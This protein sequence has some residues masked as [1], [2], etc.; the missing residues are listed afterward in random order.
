VVNQGD[1][2][3]PQQPLRDRERAN[4][5]IGHHA[6]RVADHVRIAL[7]QAEQS[8]WLQAGVHARHDR[9][10]LAR[11]RRELAARE[12]LGVLRRVDQKLIGCAH[13]LPPG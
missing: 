12:A 1:L 11:R 3:R 9:H 4:H 10:G 8:A 5:V 6:A 2:A 7:A 13:A